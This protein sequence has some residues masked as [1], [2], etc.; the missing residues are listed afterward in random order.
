VEDKEFNDIFETENG[1]LASDECKNIMEKYKELLAMSVWQLAKME[2]SV[3]VL[4]SCNYIVMFFLLGYHRAMLDKKLE[5]L[6]GGVLD[7]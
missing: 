3:P 4:T 5:E 1:W 7:K 2:P 6:L